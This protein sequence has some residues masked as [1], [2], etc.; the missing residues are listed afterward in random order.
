[1]RDYILNMTCIYHLSRDREYYLSKEQKHLL[2]ARRSRSTIPLCGRSSLL[3]WVVRSSPLRRSSCEYGRPRHPFAIPS[4]A[5]LYSG[6]SAAS[7]YAVRR[8]HGQHG[9]TW[10]QKYNGETCWLALSMQCADMR[11]ASLPSSQQ[12]IH[13]KEVQHTHK[14]NKRVWAA[15][16]AMF[17]CLLLR[18]SGTRL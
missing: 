6:W 9:W 5:R 15:S 12:F 1:M 2:L 18:I 14:G 8:I 4:D 10:R 17:Y 13:K 11:N 3:F 7:W 16:R